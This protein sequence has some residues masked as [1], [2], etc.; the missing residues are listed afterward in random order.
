MK[1]VQQDEVK[2]VTI[3]ENVITGKLKSGADFT[4]IAPEDPELIHTLRSHDVE[5]KAELPPQPPWWMNIISSILPMLLIVG[6]WFLLMQQSQGGGGRVMSFGKSR[7]KMYETKKS[8][9]PS[10]T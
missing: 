10:R 8:R 7:A 2:R 1:Q 5:I 4:T 6:I 3:V 9:L